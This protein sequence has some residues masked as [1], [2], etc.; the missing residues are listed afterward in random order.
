MVHALV[1]NKFTDGLK[2]ILSC[3]ATHAIYSS[4]SI[5]TK[6]GFLNSLL[7][8]ESQES[9]MD[10][11]IREILKFK[12]TEAPYSTI[13]IFTMIQVDM[14][15]YTVS[16][17]TSSKIKPQEKKQAQSIIKQ[18]YLFINYNLVHL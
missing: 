18:L 16:T 4:M 7:S 14:D 9:I 5:E 2:F 10:I 17:S 12:L 6:I 1:E 3:E 15:A 13:A 8:K 11:E